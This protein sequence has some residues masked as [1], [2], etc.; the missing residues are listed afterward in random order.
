MDAITVLQKNDGSM[1]GNALNN[2]EAN[3]RKQLEK[4]IPNLLFGESAQSKALPFFTESAEVMVRAYPVGSA[5]ERINHATINISYDM[6]AVPLNTIVPVRF[7]NLFGK[8]GSAALFGLPISAADTPTV[9]DSNAA[10]FGGANALASQQLSQ[11]LGEKFIIGNIRVIAASNSS[12]LDQQF[13]KGQAFLDG[14][15]LSEDFF[16]EDYF[17]MSDNRQ[18]MA[19]I[20]DVIDVDDDEYLQYNLVGQATLTN[21]VPVRLSFDVFAQSKGRWMIMNF[22]KR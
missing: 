3:T 2:Q 15:S 9:V 13:S 22:N 7:G 17:Q 1:L 16:P 18:N 21:P 8:P 11:L 6:S 19:I 14:R 20:K 12:Q 5:G 4:L 10:G